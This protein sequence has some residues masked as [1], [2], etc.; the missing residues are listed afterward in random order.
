VASV[1]KDT[2][3]VRCRPAHRN[4]H[5]PMLLQ[6]SYLTK[7]LH[8]F[9]QSPSPFLQRTVSVTL[10]TA[11]SLR[12]PSYS[13]QSPSP[14]LQHT[15]FIAL[16][17]AQS[18]SPFLQHTVSA[19]LHT[20]HSLRN[21]SYSTQS[22]TPFLQHTVS[23]TLPTAHSLR[24]PSYGTQS[25]SPFLQLTVSVTLPTAHIHSPAVKL[26]YHL[27]TSPIFSVTGERGGA[28][29]EVLRYKP[30]GRG[31]DSRWCHWNFSLT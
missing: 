18:P 6:F 24:H 29:V 7:I 16:P 19:T 22:P 3:Q 23:V 31:I 15:V 2:L 11:H 20:A 26:L 5:L 21:P 12:H 28:V 27:D 4:R 10:P 14:F 25:P 17:T 30:E 13:T 8:V 9:F 1:I